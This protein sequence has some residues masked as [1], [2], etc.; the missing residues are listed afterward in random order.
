MR[1]PGNK[2]SGPFFVTGSLLTLP[3]ILTRA[4][5]SYAPES[6]REMRRI[7]ITQQVGDVGDADEAVRLPGNE[8]CLREI[9]ADGLTG[10]RG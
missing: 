9:F 4:R 7:G 5:T 2:V 6:A 1:W 8:V 3:Q 10:F